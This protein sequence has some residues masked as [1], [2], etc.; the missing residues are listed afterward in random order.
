MVKNKPWGFSNLSTVILTALEN[1][2][3]SLGNIGR[4][5]KGII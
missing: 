4:D 5:H 2:Q 1:K 3:M